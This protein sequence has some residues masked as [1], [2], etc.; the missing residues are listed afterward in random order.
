MSKRFIIKL[1]GYLGQSAHHERKIR[2]LNR[3]LTGRVVDAAKDVG[4]MI[5]YEA[6]QRHADLLMRDYGPEPGKNKS[7]LIMMLEDHRNEDLVTLTGKIL[8]CGYSG[9]SEGR[10]APWDKPAY[11]GSSR[12]AV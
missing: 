1:R 6:D 8:M 10:Q 3:M 2:I 9:Q 4:K 12:S 5:T 7:E 11:I